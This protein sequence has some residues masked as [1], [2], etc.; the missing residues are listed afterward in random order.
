MRNLFY[1]VMLYWIEGI[2]NKNKMCY[3]HGQNKGK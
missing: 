1:F 2:I 3:G